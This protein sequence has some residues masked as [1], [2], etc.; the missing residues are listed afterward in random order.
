MENGR[1]HHFSSYLGR[2]LPD[3]KGT[4]SQ[5]S[6]HTTQKRSYIFF[7]SKYEIPYWDSSF[8]YNL[9]FLKS[10]FCQYVGPVHPEWGMGMKKLRCHDLRS[11]FLGRFPEGLVPTP[12]TR[13]TRRK[14]VGVTDARTNGRTNGRTTIRLIYPPPLT[15]AHRHILDPSNVPNGQYEE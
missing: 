5:N 11:F 14:K 13:H 12:K 7:F 6:T 1:Y 4:N 2:T 3:R 8:L 9:A 15:V 10:H